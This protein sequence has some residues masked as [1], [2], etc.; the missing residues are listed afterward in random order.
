MMP[1]V[2]LF[3]RAGCHLCDEALVVLERLRAL[4]IFE[5]EIIDL[6]NEASQE[7]LRAYS[8]EV[9]VIELDGAKVMKF[10]VDELRLLHLIENAGRA[11]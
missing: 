5:L 4:S 8:N 6:D 1:R 11:T 10:K 7:K 2:S 3:T 9:P